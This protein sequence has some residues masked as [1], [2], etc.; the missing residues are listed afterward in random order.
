[1]VG[2]RWWNYIDDSGESQWVFESRTDES[3]QKLSSTEGYIFWAG[4]VAAP[5]LWVRYSNLRIPT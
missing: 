4:L 2:L 5:V 1:M 3:A